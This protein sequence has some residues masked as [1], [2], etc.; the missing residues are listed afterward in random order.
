LRLSQVVNERNRI[1]KLYKDQL[2]N[3]PI[4][5]LEI[6][7]ICLSAVHLAVIMLH[8]CKSNMQSYLYH[9]LKENYVGTQVHYLPVHLQPY[10]R[11][12]GFNEGDFPESENFSRSVLSIPLFP[13]LTDEQVVR[14]S[15][16]IKMHIN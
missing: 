3:T 2:R 1:L 15:Q 13:G 12:L 6:P 9:K 7:S 4:Q 14:V 16:L 5:F 8:Q 10:Y 11:K